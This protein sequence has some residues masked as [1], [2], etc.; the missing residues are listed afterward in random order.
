[1][2]YKARL[3]KAKT[4]WWDEDESGQFEFSSVDDN[5]ARS[6]VTTI[7]QRM[8]RRYNRMNEPRG[9]TLENLYRMTEVGGSLVEERVATTGDENP[10]LDFC[11]I[12]KALESFYP[13]RPDERRDSA[14]RLFDSWMPMSAPRLG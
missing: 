3:C 10:F 2:I 8:N 9:I 5:E 4:Y 12:R 11:S 7:I 14:M 13:R 6:H 1:M